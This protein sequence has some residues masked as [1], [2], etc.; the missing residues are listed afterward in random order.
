MASYS[1]ADRIAEVK[2]KLGSDVFLKRFTGSEG[3]SHLFEFRVECVSENEKALDFDKQLGKNVTVVL[4]T[5]GHGD[6]FFTGTCVEAQRLG[7]STQGFDYVLILRPGLWVLS[8]RVT[9]RVFHN[10]KVPD[11][12]NEVFG[13]YGSLFTPEDKTQGNFPELEYCVQHR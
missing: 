4:H 3:M 10:M 6:R 5:N 11:I 2:T 9:S 8:K 7:R 12:L 13:E 1:Q